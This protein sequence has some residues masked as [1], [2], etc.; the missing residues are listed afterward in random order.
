MQ[1][2]CAAFLR[3]VEA[4]GR[5][6]SLMRVTGQGA[7]DADVSQASPGMLTLEL[8]DRDGH[9]LARARAVKQ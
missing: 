5:S 1:W 6:L 3:V 7:F 9:V 8:M 2:S 4:T